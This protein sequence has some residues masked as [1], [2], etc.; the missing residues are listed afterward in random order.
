M[1][2]KERTQ[3][4]HCGDILTTRHKPHGS[5]YGEKYCERCHES[6]SFDIYTGEP[7][8]VNHKPSYVPKKMVTGQICE[9][10][11]KVFDFKYKRATCCR[12]CANLLIGKNAKATRIKNIEKRKNAIDTD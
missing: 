9:Y 5:D 8:T 12:N 1:T 6:H 2:Y 4:P 10:C 11:G 3:C 7:I